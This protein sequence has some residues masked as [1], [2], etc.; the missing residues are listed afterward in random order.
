MPRPKGPELE[1]PDSPFNIYLD[2]DLGSQGIMVKL[3][4]GHPYEQLSSHL[5]ALS[6]SEAHYD[7][8]RCQGV[9]LCD[10]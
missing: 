5:L 1:A 2:T 6:A 10:I 9:L 3:M 4:K 7:V 8:T